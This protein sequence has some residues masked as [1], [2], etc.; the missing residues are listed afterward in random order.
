MAPSLQKRPFKKFLRF[1][2]ILCIVGFLL[3]GVTVLSFSISIYI[4]KKDGELTR[5]NSYIVKAIKVLKKRDVYRILKLVYTIT[6]DFLHEYLD[7]ITWKII[8][9]KKVIIISNNIE[10]IKPIGNAGIPWGIDFVPIEGENQALITDKANT[11]LIVMEDDKFEEWIPLHIVNRD[12]VTKKNAVSLGYN[13]SAHAGLHDVIFDPEYDNSANQ[14]V[15]LSMILKSQNRNKTCS[16][17]AIVRIRYDYKKKRVLDNPIKQ[18]NII[19]E[20]ASVKD[21]DFCDGLSSHGSRFLFLADGTLLFSTGYLGE[22]QQN[23]RHLLL[24][25]KVLRL[26]KEGE[27]VCDITGK[28]SNPFCYKGGASKYIY[29]LGHKNVQGIAMDANGSIYTSEHGTQKGDEINLLRAGED[30]GFPFLCVRCKPYDVSSYIPTTY[31]DYNDSPQLLNNILEEYGYDKPE[32]FVAKL[33]PPFYAW[34]DYTERKVSIAPS[35]MA[36]YDYNDK[37][38][39]SLLV[40]TLINEKLEWLKIQDDN[41]MRQQ[42][43]LR[44]VRFRDVLV[45]DERILYVL[46]ERYG[47]N[48]LKIL[49]KDN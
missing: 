29:S 32:E 9:E 18:D 5:V 2:L 40:A 6:P 8:V 37:Y 23:K 38:H 17:S 41:I 43:L 20:T 7:T 44:G 13:R 36:Y 30:Y 47:Y 21:A 42:P 10:S 39:N 11:N 25:G 26:T 48:V 3:L 46:S 19:F 45:R 34:K 33:I 1:F 15:Y 27:A 24:N 28:V 4:D 16:S 12:I 49:L 22:P 14:Y 31:T 35:G